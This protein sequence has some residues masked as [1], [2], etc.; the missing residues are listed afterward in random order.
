MF[1][2]LIFIQSNIKTNTKKLVLP[3]TNLLCC[4]SSWVREKTNNADIFL[5]L[6]V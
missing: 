3:N 1:L 4:Q 6:E 5:K 2:A